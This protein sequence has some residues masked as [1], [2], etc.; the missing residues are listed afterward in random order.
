MYLKNKYYINRQDDEISLKELYKKLYKYNIWILL[1]PLLSLSY[2]ENKTVIILF[3]FISILITYRFKYKIVLAYIDYKKIVPISMIFI[4]LG[5]FFEYIIYFTE[6]FFIFLLFKKINILYQQNEFEEWTVEHIFNEPDI[7]FK[8]FKSY[9]INI[10]NDVRDGFI[11][12]NST[13]F[14]LQEGRYHFAIA[15]LDKKEFNIVIL[16]NNKPIF[17]K[18][19]NAFENGWNEI[20]VESKSIEIKIDRNIESICFQ[21]PK[22]IE[23][24]IKPNNIILI[25][26]DA[27]TKKDMSIYGGSVKVPHIEKFFK[28]SVKYNDFYCQGE[29]TTTNFIHMFTGL[30]SSIHKSTHRFLNYK[31][32]FTH[33]DTIASKLSKNKFN[34]FFF[35]TSKRMGIKFGY[36]KGFDKTIYKSYKT[37]QNSDLTYEAISYLEQH[38]GENN[39]LVLHYMDNHGPY[40]HW[41][42]MRDFD[43]GLREKKIDDI[44]RRDKDFYDI[45]K[46]TI[47]EFDLGIGILL[48]YLKENAPD[49]NV[50]LT[51]DHGQFIDIPKSDKIG[52]MEPL[53]ADM[54]LNIPLLIKNNKTKHKIDNEFAEAIDLFATISDLAEIGHKGNSLLKSY[55]NKKFVITESIYDGTTQRIIRT[56]DNIFYKK[57]EWLDKKEDIKIL[58]ISSNKFIENKSLIKFFEDIEDENKLMKKEDD[59]LEFYGKV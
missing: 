52:S 55:R 15:K 8:D 35:C 4:V 42:Y 44:Y 14:K 11:L 27:L 23:Q 26:S 3:I 21:V 32:K 22:K 25:V 29:W 30:Y 53:F 54:M 39:F 31:K 6:L 2:M 48:S 57:F 41:S 33:F 18:N 49:A 36:T 46:N 17:R 13:S 19:S 43:N 9:K 51:A 59:Y 7:S 38:K 37:V 47:R 28:D 1:L 16:N 12:K 45:Y 10:N 5:Y 40:K 34:T 20:V 56:K 50:I 24:V 58:E